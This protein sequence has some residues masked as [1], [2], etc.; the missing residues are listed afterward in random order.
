MPN[1]QAMTEVGD[2]V[3][4]VVDDNKNVLDAAVSVFREESFYALKAENEEEALHH[5]N[6]GPTI[7]L[8]YSD[9]NLHPKDRGSDDQSGFV[10][11]TRVRERHK[12]LP[13][14]LYSA[15][16]ERDQLVDDPK[17]AVQAEFIFDPKTGASPAVMQRRVRRFR[18]LADNYRRNRISCA[19]TE[20]DRFRRKYNIS[21]RDLKILRD[22]LPGRTECTPTPESQDN[23]ISAEDVLRQAGYWLKIV[24]P[25]E[26]RPTEE[27]GEAKVHRAI[28]FWVHSDGAVHVVELYGHPSI[29]AAADT[30]L[31]AIQ[32]ALILMDGYLQVC[33]D[34]PPGPEDSEEIRRLFEYLQRVL[35]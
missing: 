15:V 5:I 28:P 22:F 31:E 27:G 13:I 35:G 9:I 33:K 3:V 23:V 16:F 32:G 18:D 19:Q 26:R 24:E 2:P 34:E 6:S 30:E 14:V 10:L 11:A 1:G 8:L 29:Y 12:D 17:K 7:D 20:V 25:G 4:L 21:G